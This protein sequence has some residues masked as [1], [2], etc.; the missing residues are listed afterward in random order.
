MKL[1]GYGRKKDCG[2]GGGGAQ[3]A[4]G[5][6][7]AGGGGAGEAGGPSWSVREKRIPGSCP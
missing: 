5:P 1:D 2:T 7:G 6:S 3:T 4:A